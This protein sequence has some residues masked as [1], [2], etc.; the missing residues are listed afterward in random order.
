MHQIQHQTILDKLEESLQKQQQ[1]YNY[2]KKIAQGYYEI[3]QQTELKMQ[4]IKSVR[5]NAG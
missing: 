5:H 3:M 1:K 4:E 2:H